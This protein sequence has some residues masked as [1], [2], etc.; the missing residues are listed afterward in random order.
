M[1]LYRFDMYM[2]AAVQ[3][4]QRMCVLRGVYDLVGNPTGLCHEG[5]A[6]MHATH[7]TL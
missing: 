7:C 4:V 3:G 6:E 5:L 1:F 2:Y